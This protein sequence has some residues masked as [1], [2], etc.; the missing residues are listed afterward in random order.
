MLLLILHDDLVS[1]F[2]SSVAVYGQRIERGAVCLFREHS[3]QGS[4]PLFPSWDPKSRYS[5][6]FRAFRFRADRWLKSASPIFV[7]S[8]YSCCTQALTYVYNQTRKFMT[9]TIFQKTLQSHGHRD[10]F[11][12]QRVVRRIFDE[13]FKP[14]KRSD[15]TT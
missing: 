5:H 3:S 8:F 7:F 4:G 11:I 10:R 14:T 15:G 9:E 2:V 1:L 12:P 6:L 13:V